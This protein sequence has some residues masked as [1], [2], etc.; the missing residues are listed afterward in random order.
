MT[1]QLK[2][3]SNAILI[4]EGKCYICGQPAIEEIKQFQ[5]HFCQIHLQECKTITTEWANHEI[6]YHESYLNYAEN[7]DW[8]K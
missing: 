4:T 1:T 8:E 5:M 7:R 6:A 2:L 3:T